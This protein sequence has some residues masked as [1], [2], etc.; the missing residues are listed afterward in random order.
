MIFKVNYWNFFAWNISSHRQ[1]D[2]IILLNTNDLTL[3]DVVDIDTLSNVQSKLAD[4]VGISVVTAD[5]N[6]NPVGRFNNF[7]PFCQLIRSSKIGAKKCIECDAQAEQKA[8]ATGKPTISDCHLGLKDCCVPIIVNNKLLGGVL[9]GQVLV[10]D[11]ENPKSKFD[12]PKLAKE[13]DLEESELAVAIDNLAVVEPEYLQ[14]CVDFYE[15]LANYFTEMGIKSLFQQ[16]LLKET[17]EKLDYERRLKYAELK[18]VEAQ[19]NPHFLFNTLNSISRVAMSE[20]APL[21]EEMI[22][23]LSDLIRYNLKQTEEFPLL[24]N[25]IK[26]IR[27]YLSIQKVRYGDRL[28]YQID[29][30]NHLEDF[31]IPYMILQPIVENAIIHGIE[32]LAKGGSVYISV[33]RNEED[34][35]ILVKDTGVGFKK[36]QAL[37]ILEGKDGSSDGIGFLNSHLRLRDYFGENYGLQIL[38]DETF[39]TVIKIFFPAFTDYNHY[40]NK[41]II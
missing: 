34:I 9:G 41:V 6:G 11:Q 18:T 17:Q 3:T 21:T 33:S 30:P 1:K 39:S 20:N 7:S 12:I 8:F 27:R 5:A 31:C 35:S 40:K 25:E 2:M 22:Y 10:D 28:N 14:D 16:Q 24:K 29:L 23:N 13:L 4:L 38:N 36:Q 19:I 26:N 32:P 37:K 15:V